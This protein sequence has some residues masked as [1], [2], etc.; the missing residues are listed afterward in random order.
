MGELT[1]NLDEDLPLLVRQLKEM[2]ADKYCELS[3][4]C[5]KYVLNNHKPEIK[6]QE[7]VDILKLTINS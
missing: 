6:A 2:N 5:H 1:S 3:N 4:R 7:L